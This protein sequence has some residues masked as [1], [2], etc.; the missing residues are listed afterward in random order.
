MLL[1]FFFSKVVIKRNLSVA[2][3]SRKGILYGRA[4]NVERTLLVFSVIHALENQTI[5]VM[6]SISI[7]PQEIHPVVVTAGMLRHGVRFSPVIN[8]LI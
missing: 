2:L 4:A 7:V 6:K 8:R 5:L 3:S 1:V